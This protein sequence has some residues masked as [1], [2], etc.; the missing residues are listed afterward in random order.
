M[1]DAPRREQAGRGEAGG[2]RLAERGLGAGKWQGGT[3]ARGE[4]RPKAKRVFYSDFSDDPWQAASML[5]EEDGEGGR[6]QPFELA[7]YDGAGHC[8]D[9]HASSEGD[10]SNLVELRARFRTYLTQWL[11]EEREG[12]REGV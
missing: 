1:Q 9:L 10:H 2:E 11:M 7:V 5:E 8:S 6:E 3:R 12:G 4:A